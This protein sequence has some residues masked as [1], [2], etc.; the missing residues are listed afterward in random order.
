MKYKNKTKKQCQQWWKDLTLKQRGEYIEKKQ[1]QKAERR[2]L[3]PPRILKYS[4]KYPWRT[5]GVNSKN[6]KQWLAMIHKKNPWLKQ[7][8]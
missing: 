3:E 8:A 1:A 4:S 7:T 6:K 5:K 2:K